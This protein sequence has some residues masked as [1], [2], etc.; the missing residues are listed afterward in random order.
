MSRN[1]YFSCHRSLYLI[2]SIRIEKKKILC[3]NEKKQSLFRGYVNILASFADS[4]KTQI[5]WKSLVPY[6]YKLTDV[7]LNWLFMAKRWLKSFDKNISTAPLWWLSWISSKRPWIIKMGLQ[8]TWD[9]TTNILVNYVDMDGHTF[10]LSAYASWII[11][12]LR[13]LVLSFRGFE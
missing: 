4:A 5:V 8:L 13:T 12:N 11:L 9:M 10:L 6:Q 2:Y 3:G 7:P 1:M